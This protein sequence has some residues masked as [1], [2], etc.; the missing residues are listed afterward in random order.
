MSSAA[1]LRRKQFVC[2]W[3]LT[4]SD[5][6]TKSAIY[7]FDVDQIQ[8]R[9]KNQGIHL[10]FSVVLKLLSVVSFVELVS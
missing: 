1:I 3:L 7:S 5:L 8:K 6:R 4:L 10:R 2:S 9:E